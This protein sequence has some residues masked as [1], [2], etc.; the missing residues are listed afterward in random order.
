MT[1]PRRQM[2]NRL[3]R[4]LPEGLLADAAWFTRMGYSNALRARYLGG[5]WLERVAR[6]VFRR[7]LHRP[8]L[9]GAAPL[10]WQ[11][12][13]VSLQTVMEHPMAVGGRTALEVSGL[14]HYA[15][16]RGLLEVHLYGDRA[17]PGWLGRLPIETNF[18]F[19]NAR[20][21]FSKEPI[22]DALEARK[23]VLRK[24]DAATAPIP[25][26]PRLALSWR[27]RLDGCPFHTRTGGSGTP[28]RA[29]GARDLPSGRRADGGR[30]Q[31]QP[32]AYE[33]TAAGMP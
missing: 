27:R 1:T 16:R 25:R 5:G 23:A 4:L 7:P 2:L 17:A 24:G 18:V 15:S 22:A 20:R 19:H 28:G 21:L 12:V 9:N 13:V 11:H 26:K 31:P 8:G 32:G 30:R 3:H 14:A 29:S 10:L 33:P 6:G